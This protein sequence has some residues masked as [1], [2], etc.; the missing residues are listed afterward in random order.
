M[1][2]AQ[3]PTQRGGE[4]KLLQVRELAHVPAD[5]QPAGFFQHGQPGR[6]IAT[7]L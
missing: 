5:G 3:A 1:A 4:Q 7:V 2:D 6:V